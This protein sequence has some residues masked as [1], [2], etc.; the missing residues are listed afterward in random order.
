MEYNTPTIIGQGWYGIVIQPPIKCRPYTKYKHYSVS[1][2][3]IGKISS[4]IELKKEYEFIMKILDS[5]VSTKI[6]NYLNKYN[7]FLCELK[8]EDIPKLAISEHLVSNFNNG[9]PKVIEDLFDPPYYQ[10]VMPYLGKTF[11]TYIDKYKDLCVSKSS[12]QII[13]VITYK[14]YIVALQN[15]YNEIVELNRNKIYHNDLKPNNLIYNEEKNDLILIDYN[16][17]IS[18]E[19]PSNY[20]LSIQPFQ[21]IV[22]INDFVN[23]VLFYFLKISFNNKYIYDTIGPIYTEFKTSIPI[24]DPLTHAFVNTKIIK[25]VLDKYDIFINSIFN[26]SLQLKTELDNSI[27][28]IDS[29]FCK[30]IYKKTIAQQRENAQKYHLTE[31][32]KKQDR[33]GMSLNDISIKGGKSKKSL[34]KRV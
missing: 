20:A 29:T 5:N 1:S 21:E 26:T 18:K 3:S 10:L 19:I 22:D 12:D 28:N 23:K 31:T 2:N 9:D 30:L 7:V 32:N 24:N 8:T 16:L 34:K 33:I 4:P 27:E 25:S 11:D 17:S 14:K 13:D 6:K 15:L